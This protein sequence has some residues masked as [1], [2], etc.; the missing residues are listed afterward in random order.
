MRT[1]TFLFAIL[2]PFLLT[3]QSPKTVSTQ[4]SQVR[5]YEAGAQVTRAV[6][7][8][9]EEGV[10]ELK[11]EGLPEKLQP[12]NI[13]VKGTGNFTL[14]SIKHQINYLDEQKQQDIVKELQAR[15]EKLSQGVTNQ[16][17]HLEVLRMEREMLMQNKSIGGQNTGL[18]VEELKQATAYFRERLTDIKTRELDLNRSIQTDNDTIR[19][20]QRQI[21]Q[22]NAKKA[23]PTSEI[24]IKLKAPVA[25]T[26]NLEVTYMVDAAGW[27]P[28]YDIRV[29]EITKPLNLVYKAN[30]YQ[31]SGEDWKDVKL[32][33]S[34]G[35]PSEGNVKR[36]LATWYLDFNSY[37]QIYKQGS[38]YNP[39]IRQVR[40]RVLDMQTG[41]PLIGVNVQVLNTSIAATT[42]MDGY[43]QITIPAGGQTLQ[44]NN[45]GYQAR[46]VTISSSNMDAVLSPETAQLDEVQ[47]A[48]GR[49]ITTESI[50]MMPSYSGGSSAYTYNWN[51]S[52]PVQVNL[53]PTQVDFEIDEKYSIP[54]DGQS[55]TVGIDEFELKSSYAHYA[56][57]KIEKDVFL[58][59]NVTGWE[60]LNLL[61]GE[62]NVFYEGAF[63]GITNLN[64]RQ[65][66]DTLAISLGRDKNVVVERTKR[67]D[68]RKNQF[69]GSNRKVYI[70]WE[71]TVRNNKAQPINL[72]I[73]DQIPVS[74]TKEIEV[75]LDELD[76]AGKLNEQT[77]FIHWKLSVAPREQQKHNFAY[78]VKYPKN[79]TV[80]LE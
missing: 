38:G 35:N 78:S 32:I 28:T 10:S 12:N 48:S 57:P 5:V 77:G 15:I 49:A 46:S 26:A 7:T 54:S 30:V 37:P 63:V 71:L 72:Y 24:F 80:I 27:Y 9:L 76:E 66:D 74:R 31:S 41:E 36:D 60:D 14:L 8:R 62:A 75:E 19:S 25:N 68:Y 33:I 2:L 69:I 43:Y 16:Q 53:Q 47:I 39:S 64:P 58:V 4:I 17:G 55:Y 6:E 73:D 1:F 44:Y 61:E 18:Q 65:T 13:Q 45:I 21:N 3:A 52:A 22:F 42:N 20:I 51:P 50:Q 67:K 40:G 34:S 79:R 59:A 23:E 29:D 11:L 70:A 56:T